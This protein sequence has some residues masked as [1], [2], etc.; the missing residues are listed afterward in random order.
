MPLLQKGILSLFP[1]T[2]NNSV[3]HAKCANRQ[4][5]FESQSGHVLKVILC[6][7]IQAYLFQFAIR[8]NSQFLLHNGVLIDDCMTF[9]YF[10]PYLCRKRKEVYHIS[11]LPGCTFLGCP[12]SIACCTKHILM[13]ETQYQGKES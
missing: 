8:N 3:P 6:I 7:Y 1:H 13:A 5:P 10:K 11:S 12:D 9:Y 2:T 4:E